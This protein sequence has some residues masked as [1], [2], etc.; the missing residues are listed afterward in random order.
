VVA[1]MQDHQTLINQAHSYRNQK[2]PQAR[3][4]AVRQLTE[5]HAYVAEN[6]TRS[7]GEA[8]RFS[9]RREAYAVNRWVTRQR[10]YIDA[11]VTALSGRRKVI[12]S[13]DAG[14]PDL[15]LDDTVSPPPKPKRARGEE[16]SSRTGSRRK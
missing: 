10:L 15:W 11:M 5:A 12:I 4:S 2:I 9:M 6:K 14:Q 8:T 3:S 16:T 7:E 1:A 13:P